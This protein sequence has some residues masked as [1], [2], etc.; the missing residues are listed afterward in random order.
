MAYSPGVGA[1]CMA[2]KDKPEMVDELTFRGRSV[3]IVT[4]GKYDKN[5]HFELGHMV[6]ILDWCIAQAKF[7]GG[8]DCYP[9]I[10]RD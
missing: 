2:I 8:V 4:Q 6:P 10:I 5:H 1:A 9:F 3:A 7:Y